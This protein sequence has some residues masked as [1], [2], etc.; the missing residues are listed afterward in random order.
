VLGV[1]CQAWIVHTSNLRVLFKVRGHVQSGLV[2]PLDAQCQ[3][4]QT[5]H[6]QPSGEWIGNGAQD[7]VAAPDP[8]DQCP[9]SDD[10]TRHEIVMPSEELGRA[11]YDEID[12]EPNGL[13]IDGCSDGAVTKREHAVA[14]SERCDVSQIGERQQRVGRCLDDH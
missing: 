3:R 5:S 9:R 8:V 1:R 10:G 6:Q 11:V 4:S 12:S 7:D 14:S 2:L 13:L